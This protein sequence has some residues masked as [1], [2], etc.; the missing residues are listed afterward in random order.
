MRRRA[1]GPV[2]A[3]ICVAAA[4]A[5]ML[6]AGCGGSDSAPAAGPAST[7][8]TTAPATAPP[9]TTAPAGAGSVPAGRTV[10]QQSC[11]T[12]HAGLGTRTYI[13]P[14]LAGRG[15]TAAFIRM[16]VVDGKSPMPAGLVDGQ[17]LADVVAFVHS[18]Q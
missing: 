18:I 6:A 7:P 13:G 3:A 15:L 10:F 17:D 1:R 12:C 9:T 11:D 2:A 16:R 4:G 14:K 8:S 5:S